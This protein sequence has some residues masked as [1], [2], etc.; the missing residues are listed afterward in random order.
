MPKFLKT[1]R[2]IL[3]NLESFATSLQSLTQLFPMHPFSTIIGGD[4]NAKTKLTKSDITALPKPQNNSIFSITKMVY[5]Q[6]KLN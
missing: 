3:K 1:M 2:K 5:N 4:I 6:N